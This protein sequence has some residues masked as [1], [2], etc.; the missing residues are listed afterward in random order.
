MKYL[1]L[2]TLLLLV[3]CSPPEP[4]EFDKYPVVNAE[5]VMIAAHKWQTTY[6]LKDNLLGTIF[7]SLTDWGTHAEAHYRYKFDGKT[8]Y[9]KY[10]IK[11][12]DKTKKEIKNKLV[13]QIFLEVKEH[14]MS[15]VKHKES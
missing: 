13:N 1:T 15:L 2:L 4:G 9:G 12:T 10:S 6:Y 3:S 7:Y 5:N 8:S 11:Y 14:I